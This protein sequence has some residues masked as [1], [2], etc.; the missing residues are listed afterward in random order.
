[1]KG[2]AREAAQARLRQEVAAGC[3]KRSLAFP[4]VAY[5]LFMP[6][7]EPN[8]HP[9]L[10]V[11]TAFVR[12]RNALLGRADFGSLYI[13]YY[14]HLADHDLRPAPAQDRIFKGA[15]AAFVLHCAARP[16]NEIV[17]WTL[18]F[19][20]PLLNLFLV[21]DNELGTV[22]GR[23]FTEHVKE[24]EHNLFFSEV[25]AGRSPLRR[26]AVTFEGSDPFK[27]VERFYDQSEQRP[28]RYF[29][30]AGEEFAVLCAHPD[31]DISWFEA[32]GTDGI[33][34]IDESETVAPLERR[35]YRWHCGCN[36]QRILEVLEPS[37]RENPEE[38]FGDEEALRVECPR[39]AAR[40]TITRE[41]MEA[42]LEQGREK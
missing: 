33:R 10:V 22:A 8:S 26:S 39:C 19:Q 30:L 3:K 1:L 14:L 17:A 40:Y 12:Y 7:I 36:Q 37:M 25:V 27:A 9:G 21:A 24:G 18:N 23:I 4:Q 13:D 35:L 15:L 34:G 42:H 6:S 28:A 16:R 38:L 20:E 5:R 2:A 29:Q 11:N 31:C 32:V 41:T